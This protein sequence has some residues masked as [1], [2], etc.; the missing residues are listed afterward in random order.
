MVFI[1]GSLYLT[2]ENLNFYARMEA[3]LQKRNEC[4]E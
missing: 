3:E 4:P 2:F 1:L